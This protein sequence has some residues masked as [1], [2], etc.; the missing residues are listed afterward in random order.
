M[1]EIDNITQQMNVSNNEYNLFDLIFYAWS[2]KFRYLIIV[3]SLTSIFFLTLL[4]RVENQ[5][6]LIISISDP[7]IYGTDE[8]TELLINCKKLTSEKG[9]TYISLKYFAKQIQSSLTYNSYKYDLI[10]T[11]LSNQISDSDLD[12]INSVSKIDI[13]NLSKQL[14]GSLTYKKYV[15]SN[16]MDDF[17]GNINDITISYHDPYI[18]NIVQPHILI[19]TE[20][21]VKK[22]M[23]K[24]VLSELKALKSIRE[25]EINRIENQISILNETVNAT[26]VKFDQT[27]TLLTEEEFNPFFIIM[28]KKLEL[29]EFKSMNISEFEELI[30]LSPL[31]H[32]NLEETYYTIQSSNIE[33]VP[34]P[35][36]KYLIFSI[37]ASLIALL[38]F[39]ILELEN[40]KR[41]KP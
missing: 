40:N 17:M 7:T 9:C 35:K 31:S 4:S 2:R 8:F 41:K 32:E 22:R 21:Q 30:K 26:T 25:F 19:A 1:N 12:Y 28:K 18:L 23:N 38:A 10:H 37:L 5:S 16:G 20:E 24:T 3:I 6:N 29:N 27:G 36:I 39:M 11:I 34:K 33:S 14:A 15:S 13:E